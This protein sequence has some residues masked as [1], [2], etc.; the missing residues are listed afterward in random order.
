M[1][2]KEK[3]KKG[4]NKK[5]TDECVFESNGYHVLGRNTQICPGELSN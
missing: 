5:F 1:F 3:K 4:V 2:Q